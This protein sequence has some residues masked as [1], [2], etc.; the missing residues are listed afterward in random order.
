MAGGDCAEQEG[1]LWITWTIVVM[2]KSRR[3]RLRYEPG[4][5][6]VYVYSDRRIIAREYF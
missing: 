5:V 2:E 3:D 4:S 6:C 1:E